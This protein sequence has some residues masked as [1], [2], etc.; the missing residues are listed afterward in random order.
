MPSGLRSAR[1]PAVN[2]I[3]KAEFDTSFS[4]GAVAPIDYSLIKPDLLQRPP[5]VGSRG[6]GWV[7]FG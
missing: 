7:K 6:G 3:T 2:R 1:A 4:T 5:H